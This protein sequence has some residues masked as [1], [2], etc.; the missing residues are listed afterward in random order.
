MKFRNPWID[1]RIEE[2]RPEDAQAYLKRTGWRLDGPATNPLLLRY[3]RAEENSDAPTLFVPIEIDNGAALQWM[4][5]LVADLARFEDRWAVDVLADILRQSE[6][7]PSAN[8]ADA[9]SVGKG[10]SHGHT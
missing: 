1:P 6:K 10:T 7:A 4:I 2:T 5:D 3:D 8:G 9:Q